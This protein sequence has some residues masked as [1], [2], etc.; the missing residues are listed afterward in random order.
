MLHRVWFGIAALS[1]LGLGFGCATGVSVSGETG[2]G[3]SSSATTTTTVGSGGMGGTGGSGGTGGAGTCVKAA[4]CA[5]LNDPCNVGTCING[6]CQKTPANEFGNCD[7][8]QYCTENDICQQGICK[9]GAFKFCP[10]PDS[11]H[12]GVCD[13][14]TKGCGAMPGNDG[15]QCDDKDACT[16]TGV[17]SNGTCSKGNPIDCSVFD[18]QCTTG[19][20]MPGVGC[21]PQP[22]N[23]N[24]PCDDGMASP[25]SVGKCIQ[26]MCVSQPANEN[27]PCD[28]NLFCTINDHCQNAQCVGGAPNPCAPPGGC[29]IASCDE[30]TDSCTAVPG[31]DGAACDD[32]NACTVNTH[33]Q[34]GACIGGAPTNEGMPCDDGSA[35]TSGEFCTAGVCGGGNGPIVYFA[36]DFH[37]SSKGWILGPEWQIGPAKESVGG[38]YGADPATDHSPSADNGVAGVVIGGNENP[39]QHPYYYLESPP[40]NT[41][42]AAGPVILG[43]FRWLNSDYDPFMHNS[44][45]V[46][47]GS[48]WVNLWTSGGPPGV[49]DSPPEGTG[50]TFIQHDLTAYKNAGMKIRFGYD[51]TSGGVF[52]VGSWNIDDVLVASAAC[53]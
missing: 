19:T 9:G 15:A 13:E 48:S 47:N 18:S 20:C 17:C 14:A 33:C 34:A 22:T 37:D 42:N 35:C 7:D 38:V 31:N 50:W 53:P 27:T 39:V 30:N 23:E 32:F 28:D 3:T 8:G 11:C 51:I 29:Y 44:V 41:Q 26:G 5:S 1:A 12:I 2:G 21:V 24:G 46:W 45:D 16:T 6:M 52:T 49:Q 43:F 40:F 4:D 10:S 25:C 36:D